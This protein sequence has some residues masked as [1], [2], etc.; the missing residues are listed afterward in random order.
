MNPLGIVS[1]VLDVIIDSAKPKNQKETKRDRIY[2]VCS[3]L[4]LMTIGGFAF[5]LDS[6]DAILKEMISY[7]IDP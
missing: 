6:L 3:Y 7:I 2:F 1:A 4:A 5:S